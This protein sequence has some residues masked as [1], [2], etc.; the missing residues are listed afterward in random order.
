MIRFKLPF[1]HTVSPDG[2]TDSAAG[3]G[4]FA[5]FGDGGGTANIGSVSLT[6]AQPGSS[7]APDLAPVPPPPAATAPLGAIDSGVAAAVGAASS[8]ATSAAAATGSG[9]H[10]NL[11]W[12]AAALAAPAS[13]RAGIQQAANILQAAITDNITVNINIHYSGTGGGAFAGPDAGLYESYSSIRTD[14]INGESPGE[15]IFNGLPAGSSIQG[16]SSIAVWNAQLKLLEA[17]GFTFAGAPAANDT[18]TDDASATFATDINPNLLV[19][20]ALHELTHALGRIPYGPQPDIFDLFRFTSAGTRLFSGN[21]TSAPSAYFSF[22]G[23]NAKIADYGQ[24]SDTS[25]FLNSGVQGPNDPFNEFYTP[26]TLQQLTTADLDQLEALGFNLASNQPPVVTV[27]NPTVNAT[28][29]QAIA[30]STLV[31]ANNFG[32]PM[33]YEFY[34]ST[35][36]GGRFYLNGVPEPEGNNQIFSVSA[37]QLSQLIFVPAF[38]SS[39]SILVGASNANGFSGWS[40]LHINGPVGQANQPPVETVF[41]STFQPASAQPIPVTELASAAN[42]DGSP[43][44]YEFYDSTPGG[45]YF[46]LNGVPQPQGNG[47]YFAVT[48]AQLSHLSFVTTFG[49]VDTILVGASDANGFSGWSSIQIDGPVAQANQPPVIEIFSS[50]VNATSSQPI[51]ATNLVTAANG[52]GLPMAYLF[53]DSTAGGGRFY[54][55]GVAEPEGNNQYFAVTAAQLSQLTFVPARGSVDTVQVGASD[56]KGFSGWSSLQILGPGQPNE[57][58][59][60]TVPNPTINATSTQPIVASTLDSAANADG[61]PMAYEFYQSTVGGGRFYLNGVAEPQGN[62]QYFAVSLAQLSQLTFVPAVGSTDTILVG[63]SDANGF[64]GWSTIQIN[65]PAQTAPASGPLP[66]TPAADGGSNAPKHG[67]SNYPLDWGSTN[68][69]LNWTQGYWTGLFGSGPLGFNQADLPGNPPIGFSDGAA[70][71]NNG[72]FPADWHL[73]SNAGPITSLTMAAF[74]VTHGDTGASPQSP[75]VTHAGTSLDGFGCH[76]FQPGGGF[77]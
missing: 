35:V 15:T 75:S 41:Y 66:T 24:T 8:I 5:P 3:L 69:A 21:T 14:L 26:S 57:P 12:D 37:S 74:N 20:V 27:T 17:D 1:D 2:T 33:A 50:T 60:I 77:A 22:D 4:S 52:D 7:P 68:G 54:L 45:G 76:I 47:Q 23:G 56:S 18:T 43:M 65:G 19:G 11:I 58:P 72:Q 10:I 16:Q 36:G 53:Y 73:I 62:G 46:V 40:S 59:V 29:L 71:Q 9:F 48:A 28:S 51:P 31:S 67:I 61:L 64:S 32:L 6:P 44:A 34:D 55:N 38:G 70:N 13:F 42:A 63:A 25:D 39:D 49:S 30:A